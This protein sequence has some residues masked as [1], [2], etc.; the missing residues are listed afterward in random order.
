MKSHRQTGFLSHLQKLYIYIYFLNPKP[1]G[2]SAD[3]RVNYFETPFFWD[4]AVGVFNQAYL[5][6]R[7][8]S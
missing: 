1:N 6:K 3:A 5:V 7:V 8:S 4:L 2:F